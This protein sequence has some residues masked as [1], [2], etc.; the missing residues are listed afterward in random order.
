MATIQV[1][2]LSEQTYEVLRRRARAAG[3]SL[4]GYM[5]EEIERL[6]GRPSDD[7][8]FEQI[9]QFVAQQRTNVDREVLLRDLDA[10]RR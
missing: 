3:M 1:R 5:R 6:A 2:D 10:D 9:E 8:L 4:Q 7:E